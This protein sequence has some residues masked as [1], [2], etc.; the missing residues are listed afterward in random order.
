M[1]L[2]ALT[3][4]IPT[5]QR[6]DDLI[7]AVRSVYSQTILAKTNCTLIIIDNDPYASAAI[8]IETLRAEA[9]AELTF[10]ADH[11]PRPGVAN[12][13]NCAMEHV[14]TDLVAFLDDDQS[15]GDAKWLE[16]L[17]RLHMELQ[18]S[19]IF[20]H[21]RTVLPE[22]VTRHGAYFQ[23]F[24]GRTDP[25][26]RGFIEAY[27]G[28]GNSLIDISQLPA[29]RPLFDSLT[30]ETG[31][32]DDLLFAMI[33]KQG[34]TFAWEPEA[35]A[36]E[37]VPAHRARLAYTLRR[38]FAYGQGPTSDALLERNY[39]KLLTWMGVGIAKFL[40]HGARALVGYA[41]GS[42]GRAEQLDLAIRG[43]GKVFFLK[44]YNLY[45]AAAL[46]DPAS[47]RQEEVAVAPG[48]D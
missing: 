31:G 21:V 37:R 13:R 30:N 32:E 29:T 42:P 44:K 26:P 16:R 20:G 38:A 11:E 4:V 8:A 41:V 10:I 27:Y 23:K 22:G 14:T 12:A 40:W 36:L 39:A 6:P 47:I 17:C 25:S 5:F 35:T 48:Q 45:G 28:V 3:I 18:P 33:H 34:G 43:L 19:V 2:P 15:A 1:P 24:F 9:P 7:I 46:R